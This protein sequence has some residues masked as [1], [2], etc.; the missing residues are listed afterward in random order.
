MATIE[1]QTTSTSLPEGFY[2][3]PAEMRDLEP[4]VELFAAFTLAQVGCVQVDLESQ[5]IEWQS[6]KMNLANNTMAVFNADDQ[7][8][9]YVELWDL[10]ESHI[11]QFGWTAVHP[12]YPNHGIH[13]FLVDWLTERARKNVALAP[14]S[15]RVVLHVFSER[16]D[17]LLQE[18]L[19]NRGLQNIRTAYMMRIDFTEPPQPAAI[20]EGITIR[21]IANAAEERA[22][23]YAAYEAFKDHWGVVNESF[24]AYYERRKYFIDSDPKYDP[25]LWFVAWDGDAVAGVSL[26]HPYLEED[27]EQGW[28]STLG[29]RRPWRKRGV[30]LALLQ[31]SFYEFYQRGK[32]R[33]GLGVDASSLTGATRLY[34]RAGMYVL[35]SSYTFELELRPG[36]DLMT[37]SAG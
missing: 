14:D 28:V 11:R 33:V 1:R 15:T 29:V 37:Q 12:D 9:G 7:P 23:L 35:R 27:P 19:T 8:V 10:T 24:E 21:A 26:N 16:D 6:P 32:P 30:G 34:E 4:M 2:A 36:K 3:R 18:T 13:A 5:R 25:T 20:P 17:R 22:A 31:H